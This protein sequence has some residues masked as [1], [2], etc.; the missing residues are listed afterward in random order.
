MLDFM[1]LAVKMNGAVKDTFL[2]FLKKLASEAADYI[3][4]PYCIML[5]YWQCRV[6]TTL[7][8][9]NANIL[10]LAAKLLVSNIMDRG[11]LTITVL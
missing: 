2:K 9:M 8:K 10:Y 11:L 7:Q 5:S 6:S 4:T 1:P 3:G